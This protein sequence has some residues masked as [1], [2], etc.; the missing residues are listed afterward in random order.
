M[1]KLLIAINGT[2]TLRPS[3]LSNA[4]HK[5]PPPLPRE[6]GMRPMQQRGLGDPA[7]KGEPHDAP[8][9]VELLLGLRGTQGLM[10]GIRGWQGFA[11]R[12]A[13]APFGGV[14]ECMLDAT[15][16]HSSWMRL[17]SL[18]RR[19]LRQ[20]A[21][22]G[23]RRPGRAPF[24]GNRCSWNLAGWQGDCVHSVAWILRTT[25]KNSRARIREIQGAIEAP[26]NGTA[27]SPRQFREQT[28]S[29]P[30]PRPMK[31]DAANVVGLDNTAGRA[32]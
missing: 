19:R 5:S 12:I 23:K 7:W 25:K 32:E 30:H 4:R 28:K 3:A 13:V 27:L 26:R 22:G 8:G 10:R 29:M 24:T 11:R 9:E 2:T 15:P 18:F 17:W 21:V 20:T 16:G 14:L 31:H 6:V 1:Q